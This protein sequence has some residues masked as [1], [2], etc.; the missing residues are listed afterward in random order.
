MNEND[1]KTL[2]EI[3]KLYNENTKFKEYIC[4]RYD[5][6]PASL[7]VLELY[8]LEEIVRYGNKDYYNKIA[9]LNPNSEKALKDYS[10]FID[11]CK[12]DKEFETLKMRIYKNNR[13][14]LNPVEV[15]AISMILKDKDREKEYKYIDFDY[16]D[17]PDIKYGNDKEIRETVSNIYFAILIYR[18]LNECKDPII[19]KE[20]KPVIEHQKEPGLIASSDKPLL[21]NFL[22]ECI[23]DNYEIIGN[24]ID[25]MY[26]QVK[27]FLMFGFKE[28]SFKLLSNRKSN[29]TAREIFDI[30]PKQKRK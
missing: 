14:N 12:N 22:R 8:V 9:S 1:K 26:N 17:Y 24:H 4:E 29:V 5:T 16:D 23:S 6:N 18:L 20:L 3:I 19:L 13:E 7:R 25:E 11:K 15:F 27:S 2:G 21:L 30:K 28:N 10:D